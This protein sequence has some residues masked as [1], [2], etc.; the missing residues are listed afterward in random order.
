MRVHFMYYLADIAYEFVARR[1][2]RVS[3]LA[4]E[5]VGH[6]SAAI[7]DETYGRVLS[8]NAAGNGA[9]FFQIVHKMMISPVKN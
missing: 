5:V 9:S 7:G 8:T 3:V 4:A 2:I 1:T 6:R